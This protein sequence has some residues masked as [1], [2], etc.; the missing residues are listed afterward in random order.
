PD[1]AQLKLIVEADCQRLRIAENNV[2]PQLDANTL[3]RWN[4]LQGE[5]PSG[6]RITTQAGE[7]ADWQVGLNFS[8]PIGYRTSR[9][10]LR[11]NE[12]LLA[13]DRALLQQQVHAS[14]H[15]IAQSLR[16]LEQF[17]AQYEAFRVVR[18]AASVNLDRQFRLFQ[19][20]GIPTERINFLNV[21][22]AV[23]DWGNAV[24][25]EALSLTQYNSELARLSRATGTILED[26][27]V[28]FV[29]E[30][31][32]SIGPHLLGAFPCYP[33]ITPP[34]P[35]SPQFPD[36]TKPA[37]ESFNLQRP[38]PT[39]QERPRRNVE[40][41]LEELRNKSSLKYRQRS[42]TPVPNSG[43]GVAPLPTPPPSPPAPG[44]IPQSPEPL[45]SLRAPVQPAEE[46]PRARVFP[47]A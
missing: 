12:L 20:G 21:L 23:T 27:G 38:V 33:E 9:A 46:P 41:E 37:E 16:N 24:S 45:P 35:G 28:Q 14:T 10:S 34:T 32:A 2:L 13:R 7:F 17:Y 44:V 11:Q 15:E 5:T 19:I 1:I 40:R 39:Q 42:Q 36:G 31:Y 8:A 3:Y 6:T 18:E 47:P 26:Q 29:E 25:N 4:G 22:L 30:Q 43:P